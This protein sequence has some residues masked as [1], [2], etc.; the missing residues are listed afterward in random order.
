MEIILSLMFAGVIF[1]RFLNQSRMCLYNIDS[2]PFVSA[3]SIE[4][5]HGSERDVIKLCY[6]PF[7][8]AII[9]SWF[10]YVTYYHKLLHN[11]KQRPT[12]HTWLKELLLHKEV[13]IQHPRKPCYSCEIHVPNRI[14]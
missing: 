4:I 13:S 9:L 14:W 5:N 1:Q 10:C 11:V 2:P 3:G 8:V 7:P 12:S 6:F